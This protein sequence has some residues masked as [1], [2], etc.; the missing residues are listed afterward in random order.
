MAGVPTVPRNAQLVHLSK[1]DRP[2]WPVS[3]PCHETPNESTSH[4][5]IKKEAIAR[6]FLVYFNYRARLHLAP[7]LACQEGDGRQ[8]QQDA[9]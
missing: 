6:L 5:P 4:N 3:P 2:L 9:Q 1:P 7:A 8:Q